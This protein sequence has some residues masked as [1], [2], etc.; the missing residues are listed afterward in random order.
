[1]LFMF[2]LIF[3]LF[4]YIIAYSKI[5]FYTYY[6]SPLYVIISVSIPTLI[7]TRVVS[8][9]SFQMELVLVLKSFI[10]ISGHTGKRLYPSSCFPICVWLPRLLGIELYTED[11]C[12]H[13]SENN[14]NYSKRFALWDRV[15]GTYLTIY[16]KGVESHDIIIV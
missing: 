9:T 6:H 7:A 12:R 14:C 1:M 16:G 3:D 2:E 11:H 10:E 5:L 15:F 8:F 13:H 4:H